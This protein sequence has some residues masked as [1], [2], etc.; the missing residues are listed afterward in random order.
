MTGSVARVFNALHGYVYGRWTQKYIRVLLDYVFP[1]LGPRGKKWWA[2]RFHFK[3][4]TQ[5]DA[6][7]I[8]TIDKDILPA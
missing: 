2:D 6:N 1:N 8:I 4:L 3:V 7:A 5:K